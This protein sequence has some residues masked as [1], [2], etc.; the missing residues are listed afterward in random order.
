M[1]DQ[2]RSRTQSWV[3]GRLGSTISTSCAVANCRQDFLLAILPTE[4]NCSPQS[5]WLAG[6]F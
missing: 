6:R 3:S 4:Q 1:L 5:N 2:S